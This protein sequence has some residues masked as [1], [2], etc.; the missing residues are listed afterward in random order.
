MLLIRYLFF[1][2]AAAHA[3]SAC[4]VS[5]AGS[6]GV[7]RFHEENAARTAVR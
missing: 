6:K 5:S 3:Y 4:P 2:R 1:R 7:R